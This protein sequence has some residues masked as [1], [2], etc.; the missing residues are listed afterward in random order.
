MAYENKKI[1]T[2]VQIKDIVLKVL[3]SHRF[4][5]PTCP[6]FISV[7]VLQSKS[8]NDGKKT[9]NIVV[10][11][12]GYSFTLINNAIKKNVCSSAEKEECTVFKDLG[13]G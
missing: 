2:R 11:V 5:C 6:I 7:F 12:S 13:G 3:Y 1:N 4:F 8:S 10:L 9:G